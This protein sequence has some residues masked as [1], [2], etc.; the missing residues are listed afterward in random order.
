MVEFSDVAGQK[1]PYRKNVSC[2]LYTS[3]NLS[4]GENKETISTGKKINQGDNRSIH[5]KLKMNQQMWSTCIQW[6]II[7]PPKGRNSKV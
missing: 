4:K 6:G 7:Y 3:N 2:T 5:P 1:N